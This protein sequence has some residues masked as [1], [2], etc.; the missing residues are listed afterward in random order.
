[1]SRQ[2]HITIAFG[3]TYFVETSSKGGDWNEHC[4]A[5]E[6]VY[7]SVWG[8]KS[9][10]VLLCVVVMASVAT[11]SVGGPLQAAEISTSTTIVASPSVSSQPF[12]WSKRTLTVGATLKA[13]KLV[14][15]KIKGTRTY[16]ATGVCSLRKGVLSFKRAGK[17][18]LSVSVKPK[19]TGKVLHSSKLFTVK[20][21]QFSVPQMKLTGTPEEQLNQVVAATEKVAAFPVSSREHNDSF[22]RLNE[23]L[24]SYGIKVTWDPNGEGLDIYQISMGGQSACFLW[25]TVPGTSNEGSLKPHSCS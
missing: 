23:S 5:G 25:E 15:S 1:M 21:K 3:E 7:P 6:L 12:T 22:G 14:S 10:R 17:C 16:R 4:P 9:M 8:M 2:A 18:R 11:V 24:V 13:S 20:A 19:N